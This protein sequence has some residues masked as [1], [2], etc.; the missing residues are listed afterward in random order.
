[1]TM[2]QPMTMTI[3][4]ALEQARQFDSQ[5]TFFQ[6][7]KAAYQFLKKN[8]LLHVAFPGRRK[9]DRKA[10]SDKPTLPQTWLTP[11]LECSMR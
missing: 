10:I 4:Q 11:M 5:R 6:R 7:R 9:K 2:T 1:M 3:A 8:G